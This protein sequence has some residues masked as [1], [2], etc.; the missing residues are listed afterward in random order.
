MSGVLST[1][2]YLSEFFVLV[3]TYQGLRR[4]LDPPRKLV[5]VIAFLVYL[6]GTVTILT[7]EGQRFTH[8]DLYRKMKAPLF[9]IFGTAIKARQVL[10][11]L[12][13]LSVVYAIVRYAM[14]QRRREEAIQ[15]ELKS[16]QEIQRIMIPEVAPNVPGFAIKSVFQPALEVGGDFFQIIPLGDTSTLIVLGDVSG[17][18]LKA[19]MNVSLIVGTLRALAELNANPASVLSEA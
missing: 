19:A 2:F 16:A 11:T 14:E 4:P 8:L 15:M 5:A 13:I 18:G 7:A 10:E 3:L 1:V 9:H 6:R 12:L 17:K